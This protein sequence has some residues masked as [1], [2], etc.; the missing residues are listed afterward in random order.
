MSKL[1]QLILEFDFEQNF[2]NLDFYVSKS[3]SQV[4]NFIKD[5]TIHNEKFLNI[6]GDE[7]LLFE[8]LGILLYLVC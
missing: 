8:F 1:N 3:N 7:F 5:W 6:I 2:K 4:F